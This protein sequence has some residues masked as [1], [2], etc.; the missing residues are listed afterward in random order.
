[1]FKGCGTALVTPFTAEGHLDEAKFRALVRRQVDLGIS[2]LVPCGTTGESPTLSREEHLRVVRAA[3]EEAGGRVPVVGGAGGYDT[4]EVIELAS[5]IKKLGAD[6]LLSVTPYYNKPNQ[7]GLYRH[8][9]AIAEAVDLPI[10]L[11]S[12]QPRT[13]VNIEP[14]TVVRL[15]E[16]PNIVAIKE[17]S[18]NMAQIAAIAHRIPEDFTLLS[19]D[20]AITIPVCSVGGRGVISV[21]SNLVPAEMT[22]LAI[23]AADGDLV[24]ARQ[25]QKRLLPLME[26][27]FF[28]TNPQPIKTM[29]GELGLVEP[30]FRLPLVPCH[31]DTVVRLREALRAAG[32]GGVVLAS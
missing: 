24:R 5:E 17:A 2:F 3:V 28:E 7:E 26:A 30:H 15:A 31:P 9:R 18:G 29:M 13:N 19:G 4:H 32:L 14:A 6:A 20:D 27:C 1:M 8:F 25:L 11:Y 16:I 10:I 12:V 21:L 23:A 22:E